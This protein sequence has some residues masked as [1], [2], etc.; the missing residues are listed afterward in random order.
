MTP[1]FQLAGSRWQSW[2]VGEENELSF[3]CTEIEAPVELPPGGEHQQEPTY[4]NVKLRIDETLTQF[5]SHQ[6]KN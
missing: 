5:V 3:T 4:Y 1:R 6:Y 2:K